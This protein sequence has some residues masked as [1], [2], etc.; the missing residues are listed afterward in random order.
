MKKYILKTACVL[1]LIFTPICVPRFFAADNPQVTAAV[2]T[3]RIQYEKKLQALKQQ[4]F[5]E[6]KYT[7]TE[8]LDFWLGL[9][10]EIC[11]II[12]KLQP[13]HRLEAFMEIGNLL[14][15]HIRQSPVNLKLYEFSGL[16]KKGM[17]IVLKVN[18]ATKL[19]IC[20]I[21]IY[22]RTSMAVQL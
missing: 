21:E 5:P 8:L 3:C 1:F 19:I 20:W 10:M 2:E 15:P 18:P 6:R 14:A 13:N 22:P 7:E 17:P 9:R 11:E 12:N 16:V 4:C